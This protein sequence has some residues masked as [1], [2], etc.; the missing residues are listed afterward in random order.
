M[1]KMG[2]NGRDIAN[3]YKVTIEAFKK[4]VGTFRK[5]GY[6]VPN[7]RYKGPEKKL[8]KE[9]KPRPEPKKLAIRHVDETIMKWVRIDKRTLIQVKKEI[10]DQAAIDQY[11]SKRDRDNSFLVH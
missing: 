2:K 1:V 9:K 4:H 5:L 3:Q 6:Q 7:L 10:S 8:E 11:Y